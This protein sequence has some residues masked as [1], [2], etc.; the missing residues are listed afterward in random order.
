MLASAGRMRLLCDQL[1]CWIP[2]IDGGEKSIPYLQPLQMAKIAKVLATLWPMKKISPKS[3]SLSDF[4]L[5]TN[6][7]QSRGG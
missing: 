5:K 6:G 2:K 4:R 7:L 1:G 3:C